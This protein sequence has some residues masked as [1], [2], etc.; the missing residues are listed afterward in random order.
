MRHISDSDMRNIQGLVGPAT[1]E[2]LRA[3]ECYVGKNLGVFIPSVGQCGYAVT[4]DHTHPA[5]SFILYFL[6][7]DSHLPLAVEIPY[8]HC[9]AVA[10]EPELPHEES[11]TEGFRRYAA[12][13]VEPRFFARVWALYSTLPP[14]DCDWR[15][16]AV[17]ADAFLYLKRFMNECDSGLPGS[18]AISP[19]AASLEEPIVHLIA[20]GLARAVGLPAKSSDDAVTHTE[21]TPAVAHASASIETRRVAE[22]IER[23]FAD[24]LTAPSLAAVAGLSVSAFA[25]RFHEETGLTPADYV[26][27][28]RIRKA[29]LMLDDPSRS[30]TDVA[31]ACG[32]YDASHFSSAFLKATGMSPRR[33]AALF[34]GDSGR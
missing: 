7:D 16:F 1:R 9:L 26:A 2:N 3:V 33:Y 11:E 24:A 30:V 34:E 18:D 29:K 20:R 22:H 8:S 12:V 4:R 14:P 15:Q 5:W 32:F 28:V 21:G 13:M 25:R 19:L 27:E 31:L 6:P 10:I 23:H 17:H